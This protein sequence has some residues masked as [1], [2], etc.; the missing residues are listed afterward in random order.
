MTQNEKAIMA[1]MFYYLRDHAEPPVPGTE[2][3]SVFWNRAAQ[4]LGT[5]VAGKWN[6]HPL[7]MKI[8]M[9]IYDYIEKKY[10]AGGG[11]P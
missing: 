5:I 2:S 6:N 1:D 9:A 11:A 7:A 4:D 3:S 8:G 10:K